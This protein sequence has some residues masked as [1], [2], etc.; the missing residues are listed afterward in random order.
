MEVEGAGVAS[1][2]LDDGEASHRLTFGVV[3]GVFGE[4]G[5]L[6]ILVAF[7]FADGDGHGQVEA[8]EKLLEISG[9]L[10]GGVDADVKL[11]RGM[12]QMQLAEAIL[13]SLVAFAVFQDGKWR[14]CGAA[15]G[16]EEGDA[17]AVTS[18]VDTDTNT[19]ESRGDRHG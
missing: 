13:Q 8:A 14:G 11:S 15:I 6:I 2:A 16:S 10:S 9:V 5:F 12:L 3:G 7:G 17:M 19:F 18:G 4:V 1:G